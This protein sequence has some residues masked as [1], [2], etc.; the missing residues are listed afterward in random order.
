MIVVSRSYGGV[1]LDGLAYGISQFVGLL[2][3]LAF[4]VAADAYRQRPRF[5][6]GYGLILI[7][8]AIF[9]IFQ[10]YFIQGMT[11]SGMKG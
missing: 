10:R 3:S 6:R 2:S 11:M 9:L 7:A 8:V 4:V 5:R 1:Q